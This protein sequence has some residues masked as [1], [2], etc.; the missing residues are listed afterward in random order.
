MKFSGYRDLQLF[1]VGVNHSEIG[2]KLY[3]L[4]FKLNTKLVTETD[5]W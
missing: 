1:K 4:M 5:A 3:F 2:K